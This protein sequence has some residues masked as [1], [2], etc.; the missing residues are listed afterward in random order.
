MATVLFIISVNSHRKKDKELITN[1]RGG[2][3]G[4]IFSFFSQPTTHRPEKKFRSKV[5]FHPLY[6]GLR[7]L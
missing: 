1:K 2:K 5:F 7:C 6:A 4:N 3:R